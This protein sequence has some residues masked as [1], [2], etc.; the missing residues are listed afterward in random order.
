[1]GI[2]RGQHILAISEMTSA[3]ESICFD[4][5]EFGF[6]FVGN[7]LIGLGTIIVVEN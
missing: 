5:S 1:M 3:I 7:E 4:S 6:E 2:D